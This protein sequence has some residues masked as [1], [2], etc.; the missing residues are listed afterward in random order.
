MALL[1]RLWGSAAEPLLV[2]LLMLL[3]VLV[4]QHLEVFAGM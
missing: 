4:L 2:P 1:V 3:L